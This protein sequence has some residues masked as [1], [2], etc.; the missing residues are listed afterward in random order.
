MHLPLQASVL[1]SLLYFVARFMC[2]SL[3]SPS[4]SLVEIT[5]LCSVGFSL[6]VCQCGFVCVSCIH[7]FC[8]STCV[9]S[10]QSLCACLPVC[11]CLDVMVLLCSASDLSF[12]CRFLVTVFMDLSLTTIGLHLCIPVAN[13]L[14]ASVSECL[15]ISNS[16]C[17]CLCS[18]YRLCLVVPCKHALNLVY[19]LIHSYLWILMQVTHVR[20]FIFV[21]DACMCLLCRSSGCIYLAACV[22]FL[23]PLYLS[24]SW[25]GSL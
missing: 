8:D 11:I 10:Y 15:V 13:P 18:S 12:F 7:L 16:L 3:L 14:S 24:L 25:S 4:P 2:P 17:V 20:V 1:V 19:V 9:C 5:S 21:L 22:L 6:H 23:A